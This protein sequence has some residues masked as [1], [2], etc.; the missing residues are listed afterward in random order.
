MRKSYKVC[1][2][3]AFE[4]NTPFSADLRVSLDDN[5][6]SVVTSE[7]FTYVMTV[8]NLGPDRAALAKGILTVNSNV[9]VMSTPSGCSTSGNVVTCS[10]GHLNS[11]ASASITI[12]VRAPSSVPAAGYFISVATTSSSTP[13]PTPTSRSIEATTITNPTA[14]LALDLTSSSS[15]V[16][17]GSSLNYTLALSNNGPQ[18]AQLVTML[19]NLPAGLTVT[20]LDGCEE[21]SAQTIRCRA[22]LLNPGASFNKTIGVTANG[23]GGIITATASVS[24][25]GPAD[26]VSTNNY[27]SVNVTV[28]LPAT[29]MNVAI[30]S[31]Q[32][33]SSAPR[34]TNLTY[35]VR[36]R[37]IIGTPAS[38]ED[39]ILTVTFPNTV[40]DIQLPTGCTLNGFVVTCNIGIVSADTVVS[41]N[42]TVRLPNADGSLG[43]IA[44]IT[45]ANPDPNTGN[46]Q[47]NRVIA[48]Q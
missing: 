14:D 19:L 37:N 39:V 7:T 6:G 20:A 42:I 41:K 3:G 21:T 8:N 36:V 22:T 26:P 13:D 35:Q 16:N 28:S 47:I 1:D 29:D 23:P 15:L 46:N 40:S 34:N 45:L 11:G 9:T 4:Y 38:A 33:N 5:P 17:L 25:A 31:P 27:D 30:P 18:P 44:S 32:Q 10:L 43:V 24:A 48:L 2:I 12:S